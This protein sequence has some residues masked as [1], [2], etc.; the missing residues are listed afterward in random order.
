MPG[1]CDTSKKLLFRCVNLRTL[2]ADVPSHSPQCMVALQESAEVLKASY[3]I[4]QQ[5]YFSEKRFDDLDFD[6]LVHISMLH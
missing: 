4:C 1:A 2:L 6:I 5:R 3:L